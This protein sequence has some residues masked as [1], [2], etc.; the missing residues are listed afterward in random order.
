MSRD[1]KLDRLKLHSGLVGK[2]LSLQ[3]DALMTYLQTNQVVNSQ[4]AESTAMVNA[5][6]GDVK[7]IGVVGKLIGVIP[8]G[9]VRQWFSGCDPCQ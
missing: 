6:P 9:E 4:V 1:S 3:G 8:K 2:I 7:V 5:G